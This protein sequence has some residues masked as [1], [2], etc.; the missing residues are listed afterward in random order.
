M[1]SSFEREHRPDPAA[2]AAAHLA[3]TTMRDQGHAVEV[4]R[5]LAAVSPALLPGW[6]EWA[7]AANPPAKRRQHLALWASFRPPTNAD[8]AARLP[9]DGSGN[10]VVSVDS[11]AASGEDA[12][13]LC[14]L[15]A[16]GDGSRARVPSIPLDG[17]PGDGA[18]VAAEVRR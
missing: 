6:L 10:M 8:T 9:R 15:S 2:R 12:G 14:F 3:A 4:G 16:D 5:A 13:V 17:A 18:F 11:A 7:A 1:R